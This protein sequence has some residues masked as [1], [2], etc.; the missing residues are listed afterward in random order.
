MAALTAAP[1][2]VARLLGAAAERLSAGA[3]GRHSADFG[4]RRRRGHPEVDLLLRREDHRHRLGVQRADLGVGLRR[5]EGELDRCGPGSLLP[6][7]SQPSSGQP[8]GANCVGPRKAASRSSAPSLSLVD[9][10]GVVWLTTD[11]MPSA[12]RHRRIR[13]RTDPGA[14]PPRH[15]GSE[16]AGQET[17]ASA[18]PA[19]EIRPPGAEGSGAR[20]ER[21]QLSPDRPGSRAEQEHRCRHHQTKPSRFCPQFQA[22]M[23]R[24]VPPTVL[25][26]PSYIVTPFSV[27]GRHDLFCRYLIL[28]M[29]V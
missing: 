19:A 13:A 18:W 14:H 20:S 4:D 29:S 28:I 21:A 10:G 26:R 24:S 7:N 12:G 8:S 5:Q 9:K 16:G 22:M 6:S 23:S 17:W 15:R 3:L 27:N 25:S 1:A 11:A 2:T